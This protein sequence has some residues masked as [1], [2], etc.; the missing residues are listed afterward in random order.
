MKLRILM[1][2][3]CAA[4]LLSACGQAA[5]QQ[6]A[7]TAPEEPS[8]A[9]QESV[10]EESAGAAQTESEPVTVSWMCTMDLATSKSWTTENVPK[11]L[12]QN[13]FNVTFEVVELGSH[14]G[15]EW[16]DLFNTMI[17]SGGTPPDIIQ[18]G[19]M[20]LPA[21]DAGW[22]AEL[23]MDQI[24]ENMPQY[25]AAAVGVYDKMPAY[26]KDPRDGKVYGICS[27]NMFGPNRHT[28]VYRKDWLDQ[29]GMEVPGTIDEFEAFLKACRTVDFNGNGQFDEYGYTSGN[30]SPDCGFNEVFGAFGVMPMCWMMRDGELVRGEVLPESKEALAILN[31]WY[32]EDLIPK[33][34]NTTETRRDGFNQGIRGSYGQ[35][36]GYAP[37]LVKGGQNYE[38]FY[39]MQ[40]DGEMLPAPSFKGPGGLWGT[41]EWG[42]KKYVTSFGSHLEQDPDKLNMILQMLEKTATTEEIFVAAMLGERGTHWDFTNEGEESGATKFLEPYT[43]YN[44][45]LDEVGVRE[46]SES[47][48]C[49]IWVPQVYSKYLDPLAIEYSSHNPG[50][51]DELNIPFDEATQ[52]NTDLINM[53]KQAYIDMITGVKPLDYFDEFVEIWYK[54]GGQVMTDAAREIYKVN[55]Q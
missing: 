26:F 14:D 16:G 15:T 50:Y 21:V 29:L 19:G 40:P 37:A 39:K 22:F 6:S 54:E 27:W 38:E 43:E 11:L 53:T 49:P 20:S 32:T 55:F 7:G 5:N 48:F 44:K 45:R 25:Y 46:M 28:F 12:Q 47:P 13:G 36:D 9:S 17:A 23:T 2:L 4:M 1:I 35:A 30:N 33:G 8:T 51:F 31:R 41:R 3:L 18:Q 52:Y 34:V 42:P 10:S 24:K